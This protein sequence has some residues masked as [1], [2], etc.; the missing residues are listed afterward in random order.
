MGTWTIRLT[1]PFLIHL[2]MHTCS[3]KGVILISGIIFNAQ[4]NYTAAKRPCTTVLHVHVC[5]S[6]IRRSLFIWCPYNYSFNNFYILLGSESRLSQGHERFLAT[7]PQQTLSPGGGTTLT[8]F[9]FVTECFFITQRALH[10]GLIPA[11]NTFTNLSSELHKQQQAGVSGRNED[12][13]KLLSAVSWVA[14]W[15][16]RSAYIF[17]DHYPFYCTLICTCT[18][19]YLC[20]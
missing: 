18:C 7:P 1:S 3:L 6:L 15:D 4:F 10:V 9:K 11:V 20:I 13:L 17:D 8:P 5:C 19:M 2:G 12:M 16:G 14:S